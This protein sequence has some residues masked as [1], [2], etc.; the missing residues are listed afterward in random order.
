MEKQELLKLCEVAEEIGVPVSTVQKHVR[1]GRLRATKNGREYI[2]IRKDLNKY[3]GIENNDDLLKKD[4][5]IAQ[6]NLKIKSYEMQ[7]KMIN[8][9]VNQVKIIV[10]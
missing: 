1:D 2:V 5:E 7:I 4:L 3:L 10:G 8:S 6:L 9:F